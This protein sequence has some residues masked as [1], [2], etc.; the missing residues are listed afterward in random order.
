MVNK[1]ADK[2]ARK[3]TIVLV[4]FLALSC[5]R[6]TSR[7]RVPAFSTVLFVERVEA[8]SIFYII[9]IYIYIYIYIKLYTYFEILG[10]H[11]SA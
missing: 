6:K 8:T 2:H 3:T 4:G 10:N 5:R 7:Q 9:Y 1:L 11:E